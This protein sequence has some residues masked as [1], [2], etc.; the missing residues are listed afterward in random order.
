MQTLILEKPGVISISDTPMPMPKKGEALLKLKYGGLCGSDLSSYRGAMTYVS[1]PRIPGHEFSAEI[2]E[3]EKNDLGLEPGMLV[4]GNPYFNC[5][6]CYSCRRGLVNCC[7]SNETMGV[8]RDGAF[9][10]YITM[11]IERLYAGK[12]VDA[13]TLALIEPFCISYH[14]IQRAQIQKGERV[15][16]VGAGTIGVLAALSAKLKGGRVWISDIAPKKLDKAKAFGIEG[17]FVNGSPEAFDEG[18][19]Q[20]TGCDGFD[21]T[22]E[23]VG[24][25][26]TFQNCIDAAAFGG[27]VVQIGVGKKNADFNFTLLQKKELH[28]LGSRNA[29]KTDFTSL[30]SLVAG[31]GIPL[32][33][34][35]TNT[36][37]FAKGAQAFADF[38]RN[39]ADMLKV[40]LAF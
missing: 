18:V 17:S 25:P 38:D 20:I 13:K 12:D 34:I 2:V 28:V 29:L 21:V 33:E 10:E 15:L 1:Y 23:A 27:R 4:T 40:L 14:G 5:G 8:Q 39:A 11:P 16:V 31:G 6:T 22:V 32:D 35:I 30:I 36:Y 19:R 9:S 3:I 7:V 26:A 24:L 37:P